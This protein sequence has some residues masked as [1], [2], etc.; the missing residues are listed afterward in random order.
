MDDDD[1]VISYEAA[2]PGSPV[3]RASGTELGRLE[4]VR[5]VPELD[6]FDGMV[7]T[8]DA[9]LRFVDADQVERIT[10]SSIRTTI[11]DAQAAQ[12]PPP[13]GSPVYHVD[14]LH[15]AGD[16]LHER[17]G[18]MFRRPHWTQE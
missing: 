14:A 3:T 16:S 7:I 1:T 4:H 18:R 5:E 6:V 11:D 8:T 15:E 13:E 2:V 9:G 10:T 17:L 12:L